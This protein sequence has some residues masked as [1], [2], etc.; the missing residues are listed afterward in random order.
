MTDIKIPPYR[1]STTHPANEGLGPRAWVYDA[2]WVRALEAVAQAAYRFRQLY[3]MN[4]YGNAGDTLND[5]LNNLYQTEEPKKEDAEY[6]SFA[7]A[8]DFVLRCCEEQ[9]R[10]QNLKPAFICPECNGLGERITNHKKCEHCNG[11]G[12]VSE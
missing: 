12:V 3:T 9:E 5:A 7:K 8:D 4:I 2:T 10:K 11:R 1:E 6:P